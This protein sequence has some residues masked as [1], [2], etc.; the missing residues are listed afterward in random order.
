MR[1]NQRMHVC[2]KCW[3]QEAATA[4][5][6]D[7]VYRQSYLGAKK[8]D[9]WTT[10]SVRRRRRYGGFDWKGVLRMPR[11]MQRL[12]LRAAVACSKGTEIQIRVSRVPPTPRL[13]FDLI[14]ASSDDRCVIARDRCCAII[15]GEG[16]G[17]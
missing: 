4:T 3:L 16:R 2:K 12:E 7:I 6:L 10:F 9:G 17:G 13:A 5:P 14:I 15:G 8:Q 1:T 11:V